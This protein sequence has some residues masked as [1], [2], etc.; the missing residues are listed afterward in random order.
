MRIVFT[1]LLLS[2]SCSLLSQD[3]FATELKEIIKDSSN[4]FQKFKGTSK[5]MPD[6]ESSYFNSTIT[7]EGTRENRVIT[8]RSECSYDA[9]IADSV[10]KKRGKKILDDWMIKLVSILGTEY[11]L[12]KS[13]PMSG[14]QFIDGWNF[15]K[16]NFSVSI[17]LSQY[18]Y[19]KSLYGVR[20]FIGHEHPTPKSL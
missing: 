13:K 10:T 6:A 1:L 3:N 16:R 7:L 2:F 18:F 20:L 5:E 14:S 11:K 19:D 17:M 15:N 4:H 8:H 9:A 12:T